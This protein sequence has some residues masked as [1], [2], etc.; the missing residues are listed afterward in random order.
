MPTPAP[1][2][3]A[4][5]KTLASSS[6]LPLLTKLSGKGEPESAASILR[7]PS[8]HHASAGIAE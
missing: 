8:P 3:A 4:P 5:A 7:S 1:A 2:K 6:L